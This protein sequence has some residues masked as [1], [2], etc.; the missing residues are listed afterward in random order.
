LFI[1][2]FLHFWYQWKQEQIFYTG[3]TTIQ[4]H[5]NGVSTLRGKTRDFDPNF[6]CKFSILHFTELLLSLLSIN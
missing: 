4:L 2:I 3:A 1:G 5:I 6:V